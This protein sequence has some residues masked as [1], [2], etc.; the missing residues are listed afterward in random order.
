[1]SSWLNVNLVDITKPLSC[2]TYLF[3]MEKEIA[4]VYGH[5]L[6]LIIMF[7]LFVISYS[8]IYRDSKKKFLFNFLIEKRSVLLAL[9]IV[10][11]IPVHNSVNV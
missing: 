10:I 2:Y 5:E 7:Q 8:E 3:E 1:M 4:I 6:E 9:D 11:N